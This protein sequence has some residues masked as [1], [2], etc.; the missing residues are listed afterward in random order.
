MADDFLGMF[1]FFVFFLLH[2]LSFCVSSSVSSSF[3]PVSDRLLFFL[4]RLSIANI[5]KR[6]YGVMMSKIS[7]S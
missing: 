4:G 6:S 2:L 7:L 1:S 5:A 3:F